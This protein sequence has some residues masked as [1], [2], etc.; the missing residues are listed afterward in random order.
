MNLPAW[1][2][3]PC[4]DDFWCNIHQMHTGE[5]PCPEID[6]W[7]TD[8]YAPQKIHLK[9][10]SPGHSTMT[11]DHIDNYTGPDNMQDIIDDRTSPPEAD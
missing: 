3:C 1:Q 6:D 10:R 4:C 9:P 7:T 8:P 5:C 2:P 11:K